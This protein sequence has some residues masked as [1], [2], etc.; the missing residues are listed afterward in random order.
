M[1][2]YKLI[3]LIALVILIVSLASIGAALQYTS[4]KVG[5]P[6]HISDCPDYYVKNSDTGNCDVPANLISGAS[7]DPD[8]LTNNFSDASYNVPG[9]GRHSGICKKKKWAQRCGVNWDGV[10]NVSSVCYETND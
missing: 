3:S 10:T 8:C 6:P 1:N 4:S 2:F 7:V 9:T 5:F